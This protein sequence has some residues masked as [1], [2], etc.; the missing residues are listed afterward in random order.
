MNAF[1]AQ[2]LATD[3]EE[4]KRIFATFFAARSPADW[5]RPTE[6]KGR[7]WTLGETIAH[8]DALGQAYQQAVEAALAGRPWHLPGVC[9]RTDFTAW[10]QRQLAARAE[11]PIMA[12]CDA[13]LSG[14]QQAATC[15]ASLPPATL[16]EKIAFPFY[17]RPST[18][19]ELF[20]AQAAHPGLVHAA[21]VVHG[22]GVPPLWGQLAPAMM[23]RQITRTFHLMSLAYW[24]ERAGNLH[25]TLA[26]T[27][28]GQSGGRWYITMSPEG[29]AVGEGRSKKATLRLWFRN[30]DGLCRTFTQQ[31]T[32]LRTVLTAQAFAW[33]DLRLALRLAGLFVS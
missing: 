29:S 17:Q 15:V 26:V 7:G 30:T 28:A 8:V 3:L 10:N 21:Q 9:R 5:Q 19:G 18:I 13:F 14:L 4:V 12:V 27:A 2:A 11:M 31:V 24:P 33:G 20:G 32:P 6:P 22:Q 23:Q 16:R 25:A 1:D